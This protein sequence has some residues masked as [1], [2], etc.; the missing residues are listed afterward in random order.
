MEFGGDAPC[1]EIDPAGMSIRFG[2]DP[3]GSRPRWCRHL[4]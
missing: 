2:T 1:L 4:L 3:L